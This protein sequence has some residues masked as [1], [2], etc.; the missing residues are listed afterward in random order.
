MRAQRL[1]HGV[2]VG[3]RYDLGGAPR[4]PAAV[5]QR[6]VVARVGDDQ[7]AVRGERGD[8]GEVGRVPGGEDER[9]LEPA[10]FGQLAFELGVQLGRSR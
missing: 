6:G 5:D 8:R 10:E 3:V 9:G 2:R 7:R 4:Q 1:A